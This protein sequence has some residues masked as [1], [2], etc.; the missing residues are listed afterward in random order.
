MGR[1]G[2]P[3]ILAV[4]KRAPVL[5]TLGSRDGRLK[6]TRLPEKNPTPL[7]LTQCCPEAQADGV[8]CTSLGRSCEH[9]ERAIPIHYPDPDEG[10]EAPP[11]DSWAV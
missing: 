10:D 7:D 6:M 1:P 11:D 2:P 3:C 5:V 4:S 9:C 8:P